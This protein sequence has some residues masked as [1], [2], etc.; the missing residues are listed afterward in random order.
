MEKIYGIIMAIIVGVCSGIQPPINAA[1][2]KAVSSKV[3][4]FHSVLIS[5][6]TMCIIILISGN[7]KQYANIKNVHPIYWIGGLLGITIVFLS[8]KVVAVLGTAAAF[9]IFVSAQI[10]TGAVLNHFGLLGVNKI[11]IDLFKIIGMVLILIG[12]KMVI[13]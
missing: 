13:R 10:I 7:F 1:L 9:S 11:S 2:G 3:A 12:V 4:A 8:I 5:T 6:I